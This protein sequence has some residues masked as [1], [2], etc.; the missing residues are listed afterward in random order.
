LTPGY[1]ILIFHAVLFPPTPRA[2]MTG[3]YGR[4]VLD[5]DGLTARQRQVLDLI[6]RSI[7]D[8]GIPPTVRELMDRMEIRGPNGII[9]HL[10]SLERKGFIAREVDHARG[11]KI[12][13]GGPK[14]CPHCNGTG[15]APA[16]ETQS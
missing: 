2:P 4:S 6:L 15:H 10:K 5:E 3:H 7:A 11:I 1:N 12:L 9:C 16:E 8:R 14:P 13:K